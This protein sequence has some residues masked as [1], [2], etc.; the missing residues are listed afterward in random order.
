MLTF[1]DIWYRKWK[2]IGWICV[3]TR[4]G[5]DRNGPIHIGLLSKFI[6]ERN[7]S[8]INFKCET[9]PELYLNSVLI[10]FTASIDEILW[11]LNFGNMIEHIEHATVGCFSLTLTEIPAF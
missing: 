9:E 6:S 3:P 10:T 11:G 4:R 5:L 7:V 8:H 1:K 2:T